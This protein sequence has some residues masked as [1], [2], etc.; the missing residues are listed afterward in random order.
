MPQ[1]KIQHLDQADFEIIHSTGE[2]L[3]FQENTFDIVWIREALHHIKDLKD[4]LIV[5]RRILKPAGIVCCLR[6]VV[7]WNENQREHFYATHPFYPITKDEGCYYLNEYITAF[8]KSGLTLEK[9]LNPYDSVI[10]TFPNPKP[11]GV[12]FDE[13]Q[14]KIR[15]KGYDLFSFF[16]HKPE[17]PE[18]RDLL[19]I[20]LTYLNEKK[21]VEALELFDK[22]RQ[23]SQTINPTVEHGR[24]I[25]LARTNCLEEA[26]VTL[27][28]LLKT[29]PSHSEAQTL[30][31]ELKAM[32]G[33]SQHSNRNIFEYGKKFYG[34]VILNPGTLVNIATSA[35]LWQELL[36]FHHLLATDE[37]VEYLDKFYRECIQRFG[38]NWH[39]MDIINV[40]FDA[41]KTLQPSIYL[42]ICV[43]RGRGACTVVR[44]C[45]D[46]DILA[47]DMWIQNYGGMDNPGP[48]FVRSELAKHH[49]RG[50]VT[51]INGNSHETIPEYFRQNPDAAFDMITVDGDHTEAGAFDD[52]CNVIPHLAEGGV[53][54]FDD[55]SHPAHSYL[56]NV[57]QKAL[58]KFPFLSGYEFTEMGYGVAFAIR[59]A[60][61]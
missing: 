35:E 53:L 20:A 24:A 58:A 6:D 42:E 21:S 47:F 38:A 17:N 36:S 46:V 12:F 32:S 52:L 25:A 37:Y 15:Q 1:K 9:V 45:P 41:S 11:E 34:S 50:K 54:L 39:Y 8:E 56:L 51:F 59:R 5:I 29:I 26:M 23:E 7:I 14:A 60:E 19:T 22:I 13:N 44:G 18:V 3:D 10:N 4:F 33:I 27:E 55:I 2:Q 49:H 61:S 40:L 30:L 31:S 16:A 48:D 28:Q 57:W 43:R